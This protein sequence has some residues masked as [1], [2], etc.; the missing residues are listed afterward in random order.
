M[1]VY[2]LI[3]KSLMEFSEAMTEN[4]PELRLNTKRYRTQPQRFELVHDVGEGASQPPERRSPPY[5]TRRFS[6]LRG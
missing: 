2:N 1:A 4:R 6:G 3:K 5:G